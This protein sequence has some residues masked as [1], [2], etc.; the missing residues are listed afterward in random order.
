MADAGLPGMYNLATDV[1]DVRAQGMY[2][3]LTPDLLLAEIEAAGPHGFV[4]FHPLLGGIPP[5]SAWR[6]LRLFEQDVLT[7]LGG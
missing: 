3:V 1:D 5:D 7:H 6:G 2:R 4:L